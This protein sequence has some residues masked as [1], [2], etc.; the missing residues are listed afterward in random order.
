MIQQLGTFC[1][2]SGW[3]SRRSWLLGLRGLK[4]ILFEVIKRVHNKTPPKLRVL[5]MKERQE[6]QAWQDHH[7]AGHLPF[8]KDCPTCLLGAGKD[9][10]HKR[11]GCPTSYTLSMDI[12]GPF[13]S[14]TDQ[15]ANGCR[16][17]LVGVYTVPID[18]KGDPLPEGLQMLKTAQKTEEDLEEEEAHVEG[19]DQVQPWEQEDASEEDGQDDSPAVVRQQQVLEAKWKEFIKDRRSQ[20]V[21]NVTFGATTAESRS[22]RRHS[23]NGYDLCQ[24]PSYETASDEDPHGSRS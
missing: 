11:L 5:T 22:W 8:R 16:Y 19:S 24:G 23:S 20:P 4:S 7:R 12:M 2:K 14:G 21:V 17:A 1:W 13:C 6:V 15:A 3:R 10:Y 18:G 9:R